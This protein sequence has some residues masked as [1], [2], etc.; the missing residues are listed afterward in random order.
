MN[1]FKLLFI[2]LT[3]FSTAAVAQNTVSGTVT[4]EKNDALIGANIIVVGTNA[5]ASTD[6]NGKFSFT[7]SAD[8]PFTI[9]VTLISYATQKIEVKDASPLSITLK[10][11]AIGIGGDLVISASRKPEKAQDAP[12]SISVISQKE[13]GSTAQPDPVRML[14]NVPGVQIQQQSASR[15]NIEM[16]GASGLFGTSVFP[17]MDYRSLVGP[18]IGTFDGNVGSNIDISRVEVVRGPGCAL[19][20]P[21]VTA[22][23][24]H[25]ITKSPIDYP[26]TTV[27]LT[28]GELNTFAGAARYAQANEEKTFGFKV[29]ATFTRGS[30]FTLDP[31]DPDDALQ[32][33]KFRTSIQRPDVVDGI[34]SGT[35]GTTLLTEADLDPDEDGNMMQD[36]YQL[37]NVNTTFEFRPADDL[38]V[39]LSAGVNDISSVFYNS[40]GEGLTQ[41]TEFWGQ[42]RVQKGGLFAQAFYVNNNG[43]PDSKPTFLYQTGNISSIARQQLEGQVQYSFDVESF[44]NANF[45]VGVDYRQAISDTRNLVYGRNEKDDDYNLVGAYLQGKFKLHDKLD[46]VLAG[47]YDQFLFLE[48]G[49][50]APRAALV[51]KPNPQHTFRASYN[52]ASAPNTALQNNIDFPLATIVPGNFDIWLKGNN[53]SQTFSSTPMI[54][55]SVPGLPGVPVG[56]PGFPLAFAYGAVTPT[57]IGSF[58]AA[59]DAGQI[60]QNTFNLIAGVL[61]NPAV[62][63]G[64][65]VTGTLEGYNFFNGTPLGLI[66]APKTEIR[67]EDTWEIGYKGLIGNKLGVSLDVYNITAKN[68]TLFTAI[69]PTYRLVGADFAGDLGGQVGALVQPIFKQAFLDAGMDDPTATATAAALAGQVGGAYGAGGAGFADNIAS[70]MNLIGTTPTEQVPD[71]GIT[72]MAA[73]YRTFDEINYTGVD[74]GLNYYATKSLSMFFNYS[75]VSQTEFM[76]N[77]IGTA[78]GV[79]PLPYSLGVPA[80]KY[81]AGILYTPDN[82]WTVNASFQHDPSFNADFGQYSGMTDEKNLVDFGLGYTWSA[83]SMKGL[84]LNLAVTNLF[85]NEYRAFPNMPKIGRRALAKVTYSF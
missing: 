69:S 16:R 34:A 40:Q 68:F 49:A 30:E 18:G 12:A 2:L 50:F 85:N 62:A 27:Q 21:G 74:L 61:A 29:N 48:E 10:E 81:R 57:I 58:Q 82:G 51:Y 28:G 25:F 9:E 55:W 43:G 19:Y 54:E 13:I 11:T 79:A 53:T 44:L 47:R 7:T 35:S 37:L 32:I 52:R 56:T 39:N 71:N 46:L 75:F 84:G 60:D 15:M 31:N 63:G 45:I 67:T 23:V 78:D 20:G 76:V 59:L 4:G 41:N 3:M 73:G 33:A 70:L 80:Q 14:V 65:G 6:V 22:G 26:G 38:T 5:G 42:A 24:V 83:G 36:F 8:Y 1:N 66:N 72:H 64:L 17:I 77:V